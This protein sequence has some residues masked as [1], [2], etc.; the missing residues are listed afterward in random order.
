MS[1]IRLA[2]TVNRHQDNQSRPDVSVET[3]RRT[4]GFE[5]LVV[6][7]DADVRTLL[8]DVLDEDGNYRMHAASSGPEAVR[9]LDSLRERLSAILLDQTVPELR[10]AEFYRLALA[11]QPQVTVITVSGQPQDPFFRLRGIPHLSKPLNPQNLIA[12]LS[13]LLRPHGRNGGDQWREA[14]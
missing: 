12:T 4:A 2:R 9:Q 13:H 5:L 1:P 6:E 3:P 8:Q 11:R 7:D 14:S 10:T